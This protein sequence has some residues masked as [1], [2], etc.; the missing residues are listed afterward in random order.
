MYKKY[1]VLGITALSALGAGCASTT[2]NTNS[3]TTENTTADVALEVPVDVNGNV[4]ETVVADDAESVT[5]AVTDTDTETGVV[6]TNDSST[7]K[8]TVQEF[9]VVASQFEFTPSTITVKK[10][11]TVKLNLLSEDVPHGFSLAAFDINETLTPGKTITV[12]FVADQAG[13]FNFI[14]N[15]VC[16][17]GHS[18]MTGQLIVGE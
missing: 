1:F 10:G 17:S 16:G 14:C 11:D 13:T 12:E 5:S 2:T 9:D 8:S 3:V 7:T 18:G 4:N 15:V 6:K